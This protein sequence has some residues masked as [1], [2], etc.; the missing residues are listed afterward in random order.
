MEYRYSVR[1]P[2]GDDQVH[3]QEGGNPLIVGQEI[4]NKSFTVT[5]IVRQPEIGRDGIVE[6][7]PS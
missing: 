5:G 6:A 1:K 2:D 7:K 3:V 4:W